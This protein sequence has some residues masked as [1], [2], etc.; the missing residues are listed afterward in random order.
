M[1]NKI[2]IKIKEFIRD[3]WKFLLALLV[4]VIV[5]TY[6]VDCYVITGGGTIPADE[7]VKVD[8]AYK[9]KGS[10]KLA[11][12]SELKGTVL[13]YLLSY[14][15]PWYE[16]G[17]LSD[18]KT[19]E[20][21]TSVIDFR[22]NLLLKDANNSAIYVA[23]T[24]ANKK[25]EVKKKNV[26]VYYI[27]KKAD[28]DLKVGDEIL[29][30]DGKAINSFNDLVTYV[31]QSNEGDVVSLKIIR[32][33]SISTATAKIYKEDDKLFIGVS[34]I[35]D[36]EYE[37]NP[38][39]E[40]V[41]KKREGGPSG[42]LMT[43]L[44]IYNQLVKKDITKGRVIVGTGTI[45]RD[46]NV[47]EIDGVKYKLKGAVSKKADIFIAPTGSNYEEAVREKEKN[48]YKIK[49]IEAKTFE[50]VLKELE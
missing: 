42:G 16:R 23:Y 9:A 44:E 45:D 12:V 50:Q 35:T 21:D 4:L 38:K 33:E 43:S 5:M 8:N 29:E 41:F 32:D 11:Y 28:T 18:Y 40:L 15:I 24:A 1:I 49:I 36:E 13:T 20:E 7:R 2:Y 25:V 27:N 19:E 22:N 14:V 3:E 37:L 48:N 30:Y 6:P 26:Y 17:D 39:M 46:G 34:L 31:N 47:G 10:F